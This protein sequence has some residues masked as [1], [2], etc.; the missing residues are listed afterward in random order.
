MTR[1][2][3]ARP[4]FLSRVQA[5]FPSPADDYLDGALDLNHLLIQHPNATFYCRVS[6]DS[7]TGAGIFDGD[8]L[9]VDRSLR[10]SHGD[11][12]VAVLDGEMTCKILDMRQQRLLAAN[13]NFPP[14]PIREGSDF[15]IEG[16]VTSSI[17]RHRCLP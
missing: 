9:I 3:S 12:V 4:C 11:V 16:V 8:Y 15:L 13:R 14:I 2:V 7:M 17:R 10:P 1:S 6:G 5:G